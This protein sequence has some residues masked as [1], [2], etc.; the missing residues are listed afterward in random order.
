MRRYL[1]SKSLLS[2]CGVDRKSRG[3][4][5]GDSLEILVK[6]EGD[7][8]NEDISWISFQSESGKEADKAEQIVKDLV[9]NSKLCK[10]VENPDPP[11][12]MGYRHIKYS[13]VQTD[14]CCAHKGRGESRTEAIL[15]PLA[16]FLSFQS[17]SSTPAQLPPGCSSSASD[18]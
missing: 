7:F 4:L 14:C 17:C 15:D 16:Y 9:R 13:D 11:C 8:F 6:R 1:D 2:I 12:V 3:I 18:G 5:R 10:A